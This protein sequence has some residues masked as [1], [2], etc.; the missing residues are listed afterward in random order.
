[1]HS[2]VYTHPN[3]RRHF[4]KK[5]VTAESRESGDA[6][7]AQEFHVLYNTF[8]SLVTTIK[9]NISLFR[10]FS[11]QSRSHIHSKFNYALEKQPV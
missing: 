1:M 6:K 2:H 4:E 9:V 8:S 10:I 5:Q 7:V 3:F 11:S